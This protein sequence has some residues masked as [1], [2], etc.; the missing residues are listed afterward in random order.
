[1]PHTAN[2][3]VVVTDLL[4]LFPGRRSQPHALWTAAQRRTSRLAGF[5][6]Q[7]SS[8]CANLPAFADR[9]AVEATPLAFR[10]ERSPQRQPACN[11]YQPALCGTSDPCSRR[12]HFAGAKV[13]VKNLPAAASARRGSEVLQLRSAPSR[14]R[15]LLVFKG[16]PGGATLCED[17]RQAA[18]PCKCEKSTTG[19]GQSSFQSDPFDSR[20]K[21]SDTVLVGARSST[22]R[23]HAHG[24]CTWGWAAP[25]CS[26][27]AQGMPN[28]QSAPGGLWCVS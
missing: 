27:G 6:P 18:V 26:I 16:S 17:F 19:F 23:P 15:W 25:P 5:G 11:T 10:N 20:L 9:P 24:Q 7:S 1:M 8:Q 4:G 21:G 22:P 14:R 28:R 13:R 12:R 2:A 3:L